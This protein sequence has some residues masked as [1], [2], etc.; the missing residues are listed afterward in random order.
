MFIKLHGILGDR[1]ILN[2]D[3][4][5]GF[6]EITENSKY[7]PSLAHGAKTLV[8]IDSDMVPVKNTIVQIENMLKKAEQI[9][10]AK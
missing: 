3:N 8:Q 10:G 7:A 5:K 9:G 2:I 1:L 4:I 6:K